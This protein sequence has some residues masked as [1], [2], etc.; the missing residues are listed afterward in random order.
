MTDMVIKQNLFKKALGQNKTLFGLWQGIP[1]TIVAE[2]SAGAGFDWL[3]IDGEHGPFDLRSIMAHLQAIEPYPVSA[4]VRPVE[5][6]TALIKQLLDIG[7]QTLLIPMVDT[8]EQAEE[9]VKAAKYPPGGSRG[10]GTSMARAANWN[11]TP[12][13][14]ADAN[15]QICIIVQI[16]TLLG[17]KNIEAI[18]NV[19]GVDGVFIGPSDLSASMGK[20]GDPGNPD[21]IA[22]IKLGF[23]A[24]QSA[25]KSA[26]VLAVSEDLVKI[27]Q[28]AGAKFIG[29]GVDA[30]LLANATKK[31]ASLYILDASDDISEGY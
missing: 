21:V 18:A 12:N 15:E 25:G 24:I 17:L 10:L 13:Y 2:I 9:I 23:K 22:A 5:G 19:N 16:E 6:S 11:R 28:E 8:V 14:L 20:V 26:G 7:A 3:L 31:L 29:V 4:L 1:D 30:A 27:Y